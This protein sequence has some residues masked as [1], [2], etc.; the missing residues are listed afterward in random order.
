MGQQEG[1]R[2]TDTYAAGPVT[3]RV[4]SENGER[5]YWMLLN[6]SAEDEIMVDILTMKRLYF[7]LKMLDRDGL[8]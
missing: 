7:V 8:L 3:V 2:N 4:S 5:S 1:K 6:L